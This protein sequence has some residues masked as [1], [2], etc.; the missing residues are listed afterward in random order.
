MHT[1]IRTTVASPISGMHLRPQVMDTCSLFPTCKVGREHVS[2]DLDGTAYDSLIP[3]RVGQY[4]MTCD[5]RLR[6]GILHVMIHA[7]TT[8]VAAC[9]RALVVLGSFMV[10]DSQSVHSWMYTLGY[11][12]AVL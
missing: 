8:G 12:H 2:H 9:I 3:W 4:H 1:E 10:S 5:T 6:P 7:A 11:A